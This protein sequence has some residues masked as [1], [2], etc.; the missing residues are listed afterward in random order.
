MSTV[1][2]RAT[3]DVKA[4]GK[5]KNPDQV[6]IVGDIDE[7]CKQLEGSHSMMAKLL[8]LKDDE[9][10]VSVLME[11]VPFKMNS[12]IQG[13]KITMMEI[14][15]AVLPTLP[16]L[17]TVR[18][19]DGTVVP[20]TNNGTEGQ[21]NVPNGDRRGILRN[22]ISQE[23]AS[24]SNGNSSAAG[25]STERPGTHDGDRKRSNPSG[26]DSG[27]S[28]KSAKVAYPLSQAMKKKDK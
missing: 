27:Q 7:Q 1:P 12:I 13:V 19:Q 24:T 17:G 18:D 22:E 16:N 21:S 3:I 11:F 25:T 10:K 20:K 28:S 4:I 15:R 9:A 2:V 5:S 6:H 8:D 26:R 23:N 14:P